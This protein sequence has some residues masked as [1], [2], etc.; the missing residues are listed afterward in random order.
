M[1]V[2]QDK[3]LKQ[4]SDPATLTS[5][6]TPHAQLLIERTHTLE[7]E[8]V[9]SV[10]QLRVMRRTLGEPL[11]AP[12]RRQ[13]AWNQVTPAPTRTEFSWEGEAAAPVWIDAS[14]D[15]EIDVVAETDPGGIDSVVTRAVDSY[16]T[17]DEFRAQFSYLNLDEFMASHGLKTVEDLR[18]AGEYLRTEVRLRRPPPFDPADPHN[19]RT[20]P[21]TAAVLLADPT[22]VLA[23]LR[24]A[25]RVAAAARDRPLP[26]STFGVRSAPYA[27]AAAF[28]THPQPPDQ[29]LSK[30]EITSLFG[31]AGI[32]PLFLT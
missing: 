17:L 14:V 29:A 25:R 9:V 27:L 7:Y 18:E 26:P 30:A 22:D 2:V 15:L 4:L 24:S 19:V 31:G 13:G 32:T 1:G 8:R 6:L 5:L 12:R 28:T 21:V 20:V 3:G 23:A 10:K 11:F 16:R